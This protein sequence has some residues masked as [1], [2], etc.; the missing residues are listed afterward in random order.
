MSIC[1]FSC[2]K[3]IFFPLDCIK[4]FSYFELQYI[5]PVTCEKRG[6]EHQNV[7]LSLP[8]VRGWWWYDTGIGKRSIRRQQNSSPSS[9]AATCSRPQAYFYLWPPSPFSSS[10]L[11]FPLTSLSP[12]MF[13]F[14]SL[15]C[16]I[17]TRIRSQISPNDVR[18]YY[19]YFLVCFQR[20]Y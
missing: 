16:D 14:E 4:H 11:S 10:V 8:S 13:Y 6:C 17:F 20:K 2:S 3:V 15:L 7:K 12:S 1:G 19:I 5:Q 9:W 18:F